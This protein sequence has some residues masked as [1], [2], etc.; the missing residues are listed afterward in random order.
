MPAFSF[1]GIFVILAGLAVIFALV[2][3]T[4]NDA[5]RNSDQP[6]VFWAAVVF[7]A[8]LLGILLY[9]LLGRTRV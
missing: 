9:L 4:Y 7:L 2:V 5:K 8:P 3:W 1:V 6:E